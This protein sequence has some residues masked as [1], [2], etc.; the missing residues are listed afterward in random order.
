MIAT[1]NQSHPSTNPFGGLARLYR[2]LPKLRKLRA[3]VAHVGSKA[4]S[5]AFGAF[6]RFPRRPL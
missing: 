6:S 1:L 3:C 4:L 2:A 5:H